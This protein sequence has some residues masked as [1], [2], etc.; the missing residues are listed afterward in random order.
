[1]AGSATA[2]AARCK[3]LRRGSF[4][5]V[6]KRCRASARGRTIV[7]CE[8][9][10]PADSTS[11][12]H[13]IIPGFRHAP[14]AALENY[15]DCRSVF[16]GRDFSLAHRVISLPRGILSLSGNNGHRSEG[17]LEATPQTHHFREPRATMYEMYDLLSGRRG[18]AFRPL[19]FE[20]RW[21]SRLQ[22]SSTDL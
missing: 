14:V 2:L 18:Y 22:L 13:C 3:N 5:T 10:K 19:I 1:M 16:K 12:A 21:T 6:P 20:L 11:A 9:G 4:M 7:N 15:T 8:A 17:G